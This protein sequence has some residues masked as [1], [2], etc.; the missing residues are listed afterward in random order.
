MSTYYF[1]CALTSNNVLAIPL[2]ASQTLN[3][4]DL[5]F[6]YNSVWSHIYIPNLILRRTHSMPLL[7]LFFNIISFFIYFALLCFYFIFLVTLYNI[8]EGG[9]GIRRFCYFFLSKNGNFKKIIYEERMYTKK[10]K[11]KNLWEG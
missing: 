9:F 11:K 1:E 8:P 10:I 6:N 3:T 4:T 5:L 2:V 7:F